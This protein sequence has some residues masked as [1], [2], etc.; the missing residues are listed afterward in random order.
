MVGERAPRPGG[1]LNRP[2][3]NVAAGPHARGHPAF[4]SPQRR[5]LWATCGR[6][7]TSSG[8][9]DPPAGRGELAWPTHNGVA[10]VSSASGHRAVRDSGSGRRAVRDPEM[11]LS[12]PAGRRSMPYVATWSE[13][14]SPDHCDARSPRLCD[15]A[16]HA[17]GL[18]PDH[19]QRPT[20]RREGQLAADKLPEA[21]EVVDE[22][23]ERL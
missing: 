16:T 6:S 21:V 1:H 11:K 13:S 19:R 18:R 10:D 2:L 8:G 5:S 9:P 7:Q 12:A 20:C 17:A 23:L 22:R 15:R 3:G 14:R 4:P